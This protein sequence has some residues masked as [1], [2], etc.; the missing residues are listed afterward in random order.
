MLF[1][2]AINLLRQKKPLTECDFKVKNLYCNVAATEVA[3]RESHTPIQIA[4]CLIQV[5][6]SRHYVQSQLYQHDQ[7][8]NRAVFHLPKTFTLVNDLH[9]HLLLASGPLFL[10]GLCLNLAEWKSLA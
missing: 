7:E 8:L 3:Q 10:A 4:R 2:S 6:Q 5:S 1:Q 9:A